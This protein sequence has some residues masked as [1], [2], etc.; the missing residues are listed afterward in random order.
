MLRTWLL[1]LG[2]NLASDGRV[3]AAVTALRSLGTPALSSPIVRSPAHGGVHAYDYFNAL[4]TLES[5]Q[6]RTTLVANLKRI[7][8]ELGRVHGS[9][10]VAI[11]IDVLACHDGRRW[12]AD[13]HAVAKGDLE[14]PPTPIL[15]R[16]AGIA[17][18]A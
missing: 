15:L 13:E 9:G 3:H 4:V 2:S 12:L 11:D 17:I 16:E 1:L 8:R 6:D 18:D 5:D 14:Q 10:Q 7:E